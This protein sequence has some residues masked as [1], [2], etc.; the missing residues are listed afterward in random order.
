MLGPQDKL[1]NSCQKQSQYVTQRLRQKVKTYGQYL[2]TDKT[3]DTQPSRC[4]GYY[5]VGRISKIKTQSKGKMKTNT[6]YLSF[7]PPTEEQIKRRIERQEIRNLL[8]RIGTPPRVT[9]VSYEALKLDHPSDLVE[10]S[11]KATQLTCSSSEASVEPKRLVGFDQ[12]TQV[13]WR[14]LTDW[15]DDVTTVI[16]IIVGK[17]TQQSLMELC[18]EEELYKLKTR[19][20]RLQETQDAREAEENNVMETEMERIQEAM[21]KLEEQYKKKRNMDELTKRVG[22]NVESGALIREVLPAVLDEIQHY[23]I[24]MNELFEEINFAFT[25]SLTEAFG[26]ELDSTDQDLLM[27]LIEEEIQRRYDVYTHPETNVRTFPPM[28]TIIRSPPMSDE[29]EVQRRRVQFD[30]ELFNENE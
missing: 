18:H 29:F 20:H 3:Q 22:A 19:Y 25:R 15:D 10:Q 4:V 1:H 28:K 17:I 2:R 16:E 23:G 6:P 14:D 7:K 9:N 5:P 13:T 26:I 30:G 8:S 11:E 27:R 12:I 24:H 21:D